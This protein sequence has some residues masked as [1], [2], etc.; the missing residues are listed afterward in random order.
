MMCIARLTRSH[1][2][3]Q[4][5]SRRGRVDFPVEHHFLPVSKT[6]RLY[7]RAYRKTTLTFIIDVHFA[8]LGVRAT[9]FVLAFMR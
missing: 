8:L 9:K 4:S 1:L 3:D 7:S 5:S 2:L 6:I